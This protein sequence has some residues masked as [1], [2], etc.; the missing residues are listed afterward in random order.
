VKLVTNRLCLWTA[1]ETVTLFEGY[2]EQKQQRSDK[3]A[4]SS[5]M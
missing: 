4:S 5:T 2:V 1:F 3:E